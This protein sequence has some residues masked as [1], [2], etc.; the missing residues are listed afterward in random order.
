MVDTE[1]V[2]KPGL[3]EGLAQGPVSL[4]PCRQFMAATPCMFLHG[5]PRSRR[6][7]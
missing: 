1:E 6:A 2:S 4:I 7:R 3:L 5:S